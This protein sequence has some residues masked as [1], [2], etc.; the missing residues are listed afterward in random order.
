MEHCMSQISAVITGLG[1]VSAIGIG[2]EK[3][4]KA[5][6]DGR[7]GFS[8]ITRCDTSRS[9][10]KIGAE[11]KDF[12]VERFFEREG[13]ALQRMPRAMQLA[14][15]AAALAWRDTGIDPGAC[16]ADRIGVCVGTSIGN[17]GEGLAARD[18]WA[19]S[20]EAA[21]APEQAFSFFNHSAACMISSFFNLR[22]PIHTISTGCNSGLDALGQ[23]MRLI[24]LGLVDA[25]LV[26]GTDCELVPEILALLNAS[27][28]LSTRFNNDPGRASRPFDRDRDGNVL[29]EGAAALLL[30]SE[31]HAQA[32]KA[33]V[34]ARLAG[35]SVCAAGRNRLYDH[36]APEIDLRPCVRAVQGAMAEAGWQPKDVDVVS[37]NGSSSVV[38]DRLEAFAL[39]EVF[40]ETFPSLRVHSIKSMLG[41]HGAGSSALQVVAACLSIAE[42]VVPPTI[43]HDNPDPVCGAMRV[44]TR[45]EAC[46]PKNVLVHAIGFGGFYYSCGALTA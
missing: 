44:V 39:A 30:E 27:K 23:S 46:S 19:A 42:G 15:A 9:P 41:Q 21:F 11:I 32:R 20:K 29:G 2:R 3:F 37:A 4:W 26:V 34:Y 31:T 5:L 28:S 12:R 35:Y 6:V 22:G 45:A 1:P 8:P 25:M 13:A 33:K 18:R 10:S 17:I 16:D 7:H 14:L 36:G 40:G 38:Y 24:Q 43:N